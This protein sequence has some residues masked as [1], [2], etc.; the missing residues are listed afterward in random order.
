VEIFTRIYVTS[1]LTLL[2]FSGC[3]LA[4]NGQKINPFCITLGPTKNVAS[5]IMSYTLAA[6]LLCADWQRIL[7]W[8]P[9]RSWVQDT[10]L[11]FHWWQDPM[12][13]LPWKWSTSW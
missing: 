5:C 8:H 7:S 11:S 2:S 3:F 4:N 12:I 9:W 10:K 13:P 1:Y 6:S